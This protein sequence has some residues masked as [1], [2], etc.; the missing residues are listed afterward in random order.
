M[1]FP[2]SYIDHVFNYIPE[3]QKHVDPDRVLTPPYLVATPSV[4]FTDLNS[5][6]DAKPIVLVFSDGVDTIAEWYGAYVPSLPTRNINPGRV[7][8]QIFGNDLDR[9]DV[10]QVL[11]HSVD[12]SGWTYDGNKAV[13][14]L[15][16]L[17]GGTD[18]ERIAE[19]NRR[20]RAM[21]ISDD[22]VSTFYIDDTS[23]IVCALSE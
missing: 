9:A 19:A 16:N 13:E 17:F 6:W 10:A 3:G 11:G 12:P 14:V 5:V 20:T 21:P 1:K 18:G 8:S 7:V 22:D 2:R 23:L 15:A 4:N